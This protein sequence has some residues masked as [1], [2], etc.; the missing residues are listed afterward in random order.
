MKIKMTIKF[1][2]RYELIFG[3]LYAVGKKNNHDFPWIKEQNT[4]YEQDFYDMAQNYISRDLEEYILKGGLCY[5][6]K[7]CMIASAI[8]ENYEVTYNNDI[9]RIQQS[10]Q[11]V[12]NKKLSLYLK[13][14]VQSSSYENFWQKHQPYYEKVKKELETLL[15]EKNLSF[16]KVFSDF[17]GQQAKPM[18]IILTNFLWGSFGLELA[19]TL[20]FVAGMDLYK[21]FEFKDSFIKTLFHEY[22]H[23]YV[24]PLGNKYFSSL[25][26]SRIKDEAINNGLD[27]CYYEG[28][29]IVNEYVV[30]AIETYLSKI[31]L[32]T[33]YFY[34]SLDDHKKRGFIHIEEIV[35]LLNNKEKYQT[36]EEF[37]ASEIVP[38]FL[39]LEEILDQK[40]QSM[41]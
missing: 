39:N 15:N 3:L 27:K 33:K 7:C 4:R 28:I 6:D 21:D 23:P 40:K 37:Y 18:Q 29:I 24:N 20:T 13:E 30:R 26:I 8:T 11:S 41:L 9:N 34:K 38:Y 2:K 17:Y 12:D 5:Y 32:G 16:S 36:F 1:D 10:Y 19:G 31:Y 35:S 14:F 25:E 22:S